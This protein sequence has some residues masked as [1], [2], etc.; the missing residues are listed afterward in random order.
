MS[1]DKKVKVTQTRST[2]GRQPSTRKTIQALGLGKIGKSKVHTVNAAVAGMLKKVEHII[3]V[4]E[5]KE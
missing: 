2:A 3:D 5:F 1:K 4:V